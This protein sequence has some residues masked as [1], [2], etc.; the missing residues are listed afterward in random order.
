MPQPTRKLLGI[1]GLIA[2]TIAYP[3]AAGAIYAYFLGGQAWWILIL[4]FAGAG[5]VW[6]FP[7]SW[8]VRWMARPDA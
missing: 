3:I 8:I 4:Y 5:L 6:F 7:A 2:L 1:F